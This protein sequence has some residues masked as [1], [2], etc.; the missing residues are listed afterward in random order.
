[1]K[2]PKRK[3][4]KIPGSYR[5]DLAAMQTTAGLMQKLWNRIAKQMA[6]L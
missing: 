3:K 5:A 2:R 6:E 1:M 4:P